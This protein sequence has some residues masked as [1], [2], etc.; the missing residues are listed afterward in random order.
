VAGALLAGALLARGAN[1]EGVLMA[2]LPFSAMGAAARWRSRRILAADG[3][4]SPVRNQHAPAPFGLKFS[5]PK[6]E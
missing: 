5:P 3:F 1:S 4:C 6:A 2:L